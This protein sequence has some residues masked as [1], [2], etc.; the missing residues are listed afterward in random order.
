MIGARSRVTSR[1]RLLPAGLTQPQ[2]EVRGR[3][4]VFDQGADLVACEEA[5][6]DEWA[7][8][9]GEMLW[10]SRGMCACGIFAPNGDETGPDR[11]P[12]GESADHGGFTRGLQVREVRVTGVPITAAP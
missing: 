5:A 7:E 4:S 11:K 10:V 6:L 3:T 12:V 9:V 1:A 2:G 8:V